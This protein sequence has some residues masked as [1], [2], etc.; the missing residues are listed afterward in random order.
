MLLVPMCSWQA[1]SC[2]L[3]KSRRKL[4]GTRFQKTPFAS[5]SPVMCCSSDIFLCP[6]S[7][8]ER[9]PECV[10][11]SVAFRFSLVRSHCDHMDFLQCLEAEPGPD[12]DEAQP[13][14][15][16]LEAHAA[17]GIQRRARGKSR[18]WSLKLHVARAK[19]RA[20]VQGGWS[21]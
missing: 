11:M 2:A 14:D 3:L 13:Q 20:K 5:A 16:A 10:F 8:S 9:G 4:V 15:E 12:D 17:P 7:N 21:A 19:Q 6:K 1:F 18:A